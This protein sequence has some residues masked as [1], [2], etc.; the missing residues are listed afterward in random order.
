MLFMA[1]PSI[2]LAVPNFHWKPLL[3]DSADS[4]HRSVLSA[5]ASQYP[6]INSTSLRILYQ[7][8]I[9]SSDSIHH[10]SA[11]LTS[12]LGNS[13]GQSF[14]SDL[15]ESQMPLDTLTSNQNDFLNQFNY[16]CYAGILACPTSV[17]IDNGQAI[18][19]REGMTSFESSDTDSASELPQ[20]CTQSDGGGLDSNSGPTSTNQIIVTDSEGNAYNGYHNKKAFRFLGIPY[21]NSPARFEYSSVNSAQNQDVD[22]TKYGAECMQNS[23]ADTAQ[24]EDCLFLNIHSPYLPSHGNTTGLRPVLLYIHGGAFESGSGADTSVDSDNFASREDIVGVTINYRLNAYGFLAIPNTA[25]KGNYGVSDMISALE[26]IINN[27]ANFGGNPQQITIV[28]ESA[29]AAAVRIL[30]GSKKAIGMYQGAIIMSNLGGA[31]DLGANGSYWTSNSAYLT[32]NDSYS[33]HGSNVLEAAGCPT[34]GDTDVRVSCIKSCTDNLASLGSMGFPTQDGTYIT[35]PQLEVG[36]AGAVAKVPVMMGN[37]KNDGASFINYDTDC[38]SPAACIASVLDISE[39]AAQSVLDSGLFPYTDSGDMSADSFNVS[40]R[41]R[42]DDTFRCIDQASAYAGHAAA[43]LGPVFYYQIQRTYGGSNPSPDNVDSG[44]SPSSDPDAPYYRLHAGEMAFVFGTQTTFRT[45]Y[46]YY[47]MQL[48]VALWAS[49][50]RTGDPNPDT[51]LYAARGYTDV[52]D[53]VQLAG[54]WGTVRGRDGP[55]MLLDAPSWS[56]AAFN[57]VEQCNWL[58]YTLDYYL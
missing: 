11:F 54:T 45:V 38:A 9:N 37:T 16:L 23:N 43:S 17:R 51:G 12:P 7:N 33:D 34:S 57:E 36:T 24:S 49:F 18:A 28:G 46:D 22:A 56:Q 50:V 6:T 26:W 35:T 8:N 15:S 55:V 10:V 19:V 39:A 27:I 41:V 29:G 1:V 14:C 20:L 48:M 42:T 13:A 44:N 25:L 32:I 52:L 5:R 21:S 40:Q 30:L 53:A 4:F 58:N 47:Y 2:A 3:L 31:V